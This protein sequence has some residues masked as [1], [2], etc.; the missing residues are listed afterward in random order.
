MIF[1]LH[2]PEEVLPRA[3]VT[4]SERTVAVGH[5]VAPIS[6]AARQRQQ[7]ATQHTLVALC[8]FHL[9]EK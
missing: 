7:N 9:A 2:G 6:F 3:E 1:F 4:E 5:V 8:H